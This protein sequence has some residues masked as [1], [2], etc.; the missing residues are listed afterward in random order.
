MTNIRT[1]K[2]AR[3]VSNRPDRSLDELTASIAAWAKQADEVARKATELQKMVVR[4]RGTRDNIQPMQPIQP[5]GDHAS[6]EALYAEVERLLKLAPRSHSELMSLTGARSNRISGI[7]NKLHE[8][9]H[10]RN[11]GLPHRAIWAYV[12]G[13]K[14]K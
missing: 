3:I 13:K 9:G 11:T 5:I 2:P 6:A 7:V 1:A 4:A 14:G 12:Q 10:V 8:T